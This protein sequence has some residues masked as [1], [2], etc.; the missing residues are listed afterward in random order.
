MIIS[1]RV[2]R[3]C[4]LLVERPCFLCFLCFLR[5]ESS[6][7]L[8]CLRVAG[9]CCLRVA[10]FYFLRFAASNLMTGCRR[11]DRWRRTGARR[12]LRQA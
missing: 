11:G 10:G 6:C 2:E 4:C 1:L 3:S 8:L 9:F 5:F 7:C 12:G